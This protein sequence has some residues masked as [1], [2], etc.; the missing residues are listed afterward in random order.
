M[1]DTIFTRAIGWIAHCTALLLIT[2]GTGFAAHSD[3]GV[4][5]STDGGKTWQKV[6]D[7]TAVIDSIASGENG[8]LIAATA[9]YLSGPGMEYGIYYAARGTTRWGKATFFDAPT[10]NVDVRSLLSVAGSEIIAAGSAGVH[11]SSDD[12]ATWKQLSAPIP[13][14]TFQA[15]AKSSQG[16]LL[17]GASDGIYHSTDGGSHWTKL[18][19]R[20]KTVTSLVVAPNGQLLAGT[21]R[22]GLFSSST[23]GQSW[24]PASSLSG[25]T[26]SALG[27]DKTGHVYAS[28][29][30]RGIVKSGDGGRTWINTLSLGKNTATYA[31]SVAPGGEIYA[32]AGECCPVNVMYLF[33]SRDGGKTWERIL[34]V[35]DGVAIGSIVA[36]RDG[37]VFVGLTTVG[38]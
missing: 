21:A 6:L 35:A 5:Q 36:A 30:G 29:V 19:L 18:G 27:V 32:A 16:V 12:G 22:N 20:G 26:I 14:V 24:S 28:V 2:A 10:G 15:L 9:G 17:A 38:E 8:G 7:G 3:Y 31:L 1:S 37:T 4:L 13:G 11:R 25:N 34:Q 33:R 23:S